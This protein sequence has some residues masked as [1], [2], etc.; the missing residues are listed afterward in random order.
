VSREEE[1]EQRARALEEQFA[2]EEAERRT[3]EEAVRAERDREWRG[4]IEAERIEREKAREASEQADERRRAARQSERDAVR[5]EAKRAARAQA[6]ERAREAAAS[7][8]AAVRDAQNTVRAR[9]LVV[10]APPTYTSE[11][12]AR[13]DAEIQSLISGLDDA[14]MAAAT[15]R[16]RA[17]VGDRP[18]GTLAAWLEEL[19][20]P[21]APAAPMTPEA[22]LEY[23]RGLREGVSAGT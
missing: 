22:A 12:L 2:R 21:R 15:K 7:A 8:A 4:K 3:R 13:F 5:E 1:E 19:S 10:A 23:L 17:L 6:E 18:A 11:D 16:A 9:P 14:R 20:A